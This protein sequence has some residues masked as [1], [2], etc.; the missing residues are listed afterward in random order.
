MKYAAAKQTKLLHTVQSL[1]ET[2]TQHEG[3]IS[4]QNESLRQYD[5]L[6]D[7]WQHQ[8]ETIR[9]QQQQCTTELVAERASTAALVQTI[10]GRDEHI[11]YLK[12]QIADLQTAVCRMAGWHETVVRPQL[13]SLRRQFE[14]VNASYGNLQDHLLDHSDDLQTV[15]KELNIDAISENG[16]IC[17]NGDEADDT[18]CGDDDG[19]AGPASTNPAH[20]EVNHKN[21]RSTEQDEEPVDDESAMVRVAQAASHVLE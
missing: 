16:G 12:E 20:G 13:D 6:Q 17:G 1:H 11:H 4:Q 15:L 19:G 21:N 14:L 8:Y 3:T 2:I 7:Q 9:Q 18:L 5:E 10:A